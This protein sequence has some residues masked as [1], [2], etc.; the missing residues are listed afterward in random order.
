MPRQPAAT[1]WCSQNLLADNH[2]GKFAWE[3][4]P[5]DFLQAK[6]DC[7][8]LRSCWKLLAPRPFKT[9]CVSTKWLATGRS[10]RKRWT[11][12]ATTLMVKVNIV[13][14]TRQMTTSQWFSVIE[15][16]ATLS[17]KRIRQRFGIHS[18]RCN[19]PTPAKTGRSSALASIAGIA[20][21]STRIFGNQPMG[22]GLS[23]IA[24]GM[25]I[26]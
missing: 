24:C 17:S 16:W 3:L 7:Q 22:A 20:T 15:S 8:S 19:W 23:I 26:V 4:R 25:A 12:I 11:A 10:T 6:L 5:Y 14:A 2:R 9:Q 18:R 21:A 13:D 1:L